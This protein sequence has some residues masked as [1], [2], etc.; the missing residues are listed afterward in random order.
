LQEQESK[1]ASKILQ[2]SL[3]EEWTNHGIRSNFRGQSVPGYIALSVK[4]GKA[5]SFFDQKRRELPQKVQSAYVEPVKKFIEEEFN[6]LG[7]V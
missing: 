5:Y 6:Q 3:G 2:V 4:L 1:D 7:K